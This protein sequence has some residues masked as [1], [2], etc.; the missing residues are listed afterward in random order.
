MI[1]DL[2]HTFYNEYIYLYVCRI[3]L[4]ELFYFQ[5]FINH[6]SCVLMTDSGMLEDHRCSAQKAYI[7]SYRNQGE[8]CFFTT[9]IRL[10][11]Y[12]R[13]SVYPCLCVRHVCVSLVTF[14]NKFAVILCQVSLINEHLYVLSIWLSGWWGDETML[15]IAKSFN[16]HKFKCRHAHALGRTGQVGHT[17]TKWT[18]ISLICVVPKKKIATW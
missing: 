11:V 1:N 7:C 13:L 14:L 5:S 18:I 8:S 17:F 12:H 6:Q 15:F 16:T 4:L 10:S 3:Y 2:I 9:C